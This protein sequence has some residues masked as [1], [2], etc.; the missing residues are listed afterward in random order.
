[1]GAMLALNVI[2]VQNNF[3][4]VCS[5]FYGGETTLPQRKLW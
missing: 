2:D 5:R 1:M 3:T 4:A